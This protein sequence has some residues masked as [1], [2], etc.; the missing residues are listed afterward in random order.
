MLEA[1]HA[2]KPSAIV[3]VSAQAGMFTREVLEAMAR[4]NQRPMVFALSNPT[5]KA[6]CTAKEAYSWTEG[7]AIFASGSPFEPV[8]LNGQTFRPGQ[9][10][11]AYIFPGVGLGVIASGATRVTDNMFAAAAATLADMVSEND[12][13][14][15]LIYPPLAKIREVSARIAVAVAKEAITS[16]LSTGHIPPDLDMHIRSQMYDPNYSEYA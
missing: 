12:L 1:V 13:K 11:N 5:S 7:R 15:G 10:N 8:T 6:E 9:G 3:G 16:G 2:L 14:Q 4:Y